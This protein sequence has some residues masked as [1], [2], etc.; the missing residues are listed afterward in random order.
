MLAGVLSVLECRQAEGGRRARHLY[1]ISIDGTPFALKKV[2]EGWLDAAI[3]Q[4]LNLYVK[5]G[6]AYCRPRSR[7]S[8]SRRTDRPTAESTSSTAI[9]WTSFRRRWSP[10]PTSTTSPAGAIGQIAAMAARQ[11]AP[12]SRRGRSG[13]CGS[14]RIAGRRDDRRLEALRCGPSARRCLAGHRPRRSRALVGRNGAGK[15][16]LVAVRMACWR[17]CRPGRLA[18]EGAPGLADRQRWRERVACVY[19][20]RP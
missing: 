11:P 15:S 12:E 8:R 17:R 4:P 10:R 5:Y 6:L 2:R 16:T 13:H 1:L 3:S 20:S 9:R 18:G 14:V 7:A 19:R